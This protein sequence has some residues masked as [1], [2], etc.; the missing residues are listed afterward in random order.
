M[1]TNIFFQ[2]TICLP[3]PP[4]TGWVIKFPPGVHHSLD[5]VV[6]DGHSSLDN[7]GNDCSKSCLHLNSTAYSVLFLCF[8]SK[9][10]TARKLHAHVCGGAKQPADIH[11][12]PTQLKS[13]PKED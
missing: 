13:K 12:I 10:N 11:L 3:L 9:W 2:K 6:L 1:V 8:F 7:G 4:Y 5:Q